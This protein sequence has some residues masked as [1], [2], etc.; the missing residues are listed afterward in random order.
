MIHGYRGL[1]LRTLATLRLSGLLLAEGG[2]AL[3]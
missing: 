2:M 3:G 1:S